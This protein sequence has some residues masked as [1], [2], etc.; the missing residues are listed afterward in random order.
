MTDNSIEIAES[1]LNTLYEQGER[2]DKILS[3]YN[4]CAEVFK[5]VLSN[6]A[7]YKAPPKH[8]NDTNEIFE[9]KHKLK[10]LLELNLKI[11]ETLKLQ[12][13]TLK[14]LTLKDG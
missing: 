7:Y 10:Q 8:N 14:K 9:P 13:D 12:N 6:K 5:N 4:Y 11:N 1:T 3:M 2:I